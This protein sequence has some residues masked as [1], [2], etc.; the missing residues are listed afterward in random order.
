MSNQIRIRKI[1]NDLKWLGLILPFV[2]ILLVFAYYPVMQC[3][4]G[5]FYKIP[6][7]GNVYSGTFNGLGNYK[8]VF[9]DKRFITSTYITFALM[10]YS[11][12]YIPLAFLFACLINNL[13][14]GKLQSVFRVIFFTP[15]VIPMV[16]VIMIF[17]VFLKGSDGTLNVLLSNLVGKEIITGWLSDPS[18]ARFGVSIISNYSNLPYGIIIFLAGLQS[19]PSELYEAASIDG[20]NAVQKLRR[21]TL[22]GIIGTAFFL[23]TTQI[24][25]GFQRV[26]DL[27]IVGL[28]RPVGAPGGSLQSLMMYIYQL[29][30]YSNT[31]ISFNYGVVFAATTL[32]VAIILIV[33]LLV[34]FFT[35]KIRNG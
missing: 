11:L 22:P 14:K 18:I 21:I 33:T 7:I 19:I 16:A 32:L 1:R 4:A 15:Y 30:F 17:Q 20:A 31:S 3:I 12:L 2:L 34:F 10:L 29:S 8:V 9:S 13:G 35:K 23:I 26:T 24:I 25:F 5:S 6:D 28:G 27:L